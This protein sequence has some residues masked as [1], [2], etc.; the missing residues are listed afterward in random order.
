MM[1]AVVIG[2]G[3]PLAVYI[4]AITAWVLTV[5]PKGFDNEYD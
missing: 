2:L 3:V 1:G 4:G 5:G